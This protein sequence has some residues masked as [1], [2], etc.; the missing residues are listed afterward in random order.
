[1][2]WPTRVCVCVC[3]CVCVWCVCV[4]VCVCCVCVAAAGCTFYLHV[5][6]LL[7]AL[8]IVR[9]GSRSA[10]PRDAMGRSPTVDNTRDPTGMLSPEGKIRLQVSVCVCLCVCVC[11]CVCVRVCV[12]ACVCVC[13]VCSASMCYRVC[14]NAQWHRETEVG[15]D[16]YVATQHT[17]WET[18]KA[19]RPVPGGLIL[20]QTMQVR[21]C[22]CSAVVERVVFEPPS[23]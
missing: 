19:V 1:M 17:F 20:D 22:V 16:L 13:R 14:R 4:C 21:S 8:Q 11:V 23:L 12:L 3:V 2:F 7:F 6:C 18:P 15:S 9:G 5:C 10:S